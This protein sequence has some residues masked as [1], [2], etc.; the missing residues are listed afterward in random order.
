MAQAQLDRVNFKLAEREPWPMEGMSCEVEGCTTPIFR[1]HSI[2][3]KH[4]K[5]KHLSV[6]PVFECPYCRLREAPSRFARR[7][8]VTRHLLFTH[9]FTSAQT[10]E[11]V[12]TLTPQLPNMNFLDPGSVMPRRYVPLS[13]VTVNVKARENARKEREAIAQE[14]QLKYPNGPFP[15]QNGQVWWVIPW[16]IERTCHNQDIGRS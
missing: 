12:E 9:H 5:R 14:I 4:C 1:N 2:F 13:I 15:K 7:C 8:E 11:I 10:K 16:Q 3:M 6:V